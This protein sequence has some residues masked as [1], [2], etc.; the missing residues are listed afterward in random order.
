MSSEKKAKKNGRGKK[1]ALIIIFILLL[2]IAG[3]YIAVTQLLDFEEEEARP[4]EEFVDVLSEDDDEGTIDTLNELRDAGDLSTILKEWAMSTDD[5]G[6][7]RSDKVKNILIIGLDKSEYNSDVIMLLS[8]NT[9]T[10]RIYLSSLFRDSYTYINTSSGSTFAKINAAYGNGGAKLL[11]E[12]V[13]RDYK[14]KIDNY[15][16]INF[17]SFIDVVDI[18]GGVSVPV[19][20]YEADAI[21]LENCEISS[22]GDNVLLNGE[23]ALWYCRIRKCD[24]DGDVSRTRRQRAFITA[25]VDRSRELTLSQIKPILS[26]LMEYVKTDFTSSELVSLA[27]QALIGKWYGYKIES[28]SFPQTEHRLDYLGYAWV[29]IVDYPAAAQ[30]LQNRIYGESNITLAENRLTAIDVVNQGLTGTA[31]P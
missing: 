21:R 26:T 3:G 17:Q 16:S 18:I 14:I 2:L 29:W 11:C 12:T 22:V 27:T 5:S 1:A 9:E 13:E 24:V 6:L 8:I 28:D 20:Q 25:L 7:M 15:V 23:Q 30:D 31:N 4:E 10:K 19:Q